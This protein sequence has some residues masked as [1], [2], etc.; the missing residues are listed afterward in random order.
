MTGKRYGLLGH[1]NIYSVFASAALSRTR[2]IMRYFYL[3]AIYALQISYDVFKGHIWHG[4]P[5]QHSA[6][7]GRTTLTFD[8]LTISLVVLLGFGIG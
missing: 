4:W 2:S 8:N 6:R 3:Q 5:A 7:H 1:F